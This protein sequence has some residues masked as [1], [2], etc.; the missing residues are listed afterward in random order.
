MTLTGR[1]QSLRLALFLVTPVVAAVVVALSR[2]VRVGLGAAPIN[3]SIDQLF[4]VTG[5]LVSVGLGLIFVAVYLRLFRRTPSLSVFFVIWFFL[6]MAIDVS[7]LGQV[8]LPGSPW[9]QLVPVVSRVSIFGHI[10]GV[11]ALFSAGLYEGG[12]RMQRHGTAMFVAVLLAVGLSWSV[13]IDTSVLPPHL[14]YPAGM[15]ASLRATLVV[16]L[17]VAVVNYLEAAISSG[18]PRQLSAAAAVFL[19]AT[20]REVLFYQTAPLWIVLG[21]AAVLAGG[22]LFAVHNFRDFLVS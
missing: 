13:P 8:I 7:K 6:S 16:L 11:M 10:I 4:A 15:R 3:L 1:N 5:A 17:V 19:L 12:V 22:I 14:V 21:A 20:G 9:P 2:A 18:N